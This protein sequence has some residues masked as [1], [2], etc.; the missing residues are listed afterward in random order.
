[1]TVFD[2]ASEHA[3]L[4]A[5]CFDIMS[6]V[7]ADQHQL[8]LGFVDGWQGGDLLFTS[9]TSTSPMPQ[10]AQKGHVIAASRFAVFRVE[11]L[12]L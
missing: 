10:P 9:L 3:G 4:Q 5:R 8:Y 11:T 2:I 6:C 12:Q 1:M 7:Q